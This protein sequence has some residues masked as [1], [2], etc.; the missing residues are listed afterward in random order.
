MNTMTA[1]MDIMI[2]EYPAPAKTGSFAPCEPMPRLPV[3][4]GLLP[5]G[6]SLASLLRDRIEPCSRR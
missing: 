1:A 5:Y 2:A 3:A 6:L 4:A